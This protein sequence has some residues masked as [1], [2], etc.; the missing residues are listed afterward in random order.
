M[1][2]LD[3]NLMTT[4]MRKITVS[5]YMREM[6]DSLSEFNI[7]IPTEINSIILLYTAEGMYIIQYNSRPF[8][9]S[10]IM[11]FQGKN[12]IISSIQ[13]ETN[14]ERGMKVASRLYAIDDTIVMDLKHK[15][16]LKLMVAAKMPVRLAF[17]KVFILH[18]IYLQNK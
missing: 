2:G 4:K 18:S 17:L 13:E 5:G 1:A 6:N 7:F 16:I 8:G 12:V 10:G 11:D 14:I 3:V 9:F 15:K